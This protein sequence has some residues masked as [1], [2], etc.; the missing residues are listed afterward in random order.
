MLR[1]MVKTLAAAMIFA[2]AA[3]VVAQVAQG[4]LAPAAPVRTAEYRLL[5]GDEIA[6]KMPLNPELDTTGPIGPDGRFSIP[7]AGRVAISGLTLGE[8][9]RAITASLRDGRIVADPKPGIVVLKYTG[10]VYV[11]GE[12][13]KPGP[14]PVAQ[15]LDPLQAIIS[16][17]GLLNTA[18]SRK[19]AIIH[20]AAAPG[21]PRIETVDVR[22]IVRTG[23]TGTG[24]RPPLLLQPGD[25]IFVPKSTIAEVDQFVDQYIN[26]IVPNRLNFNVNLHNGTNTT[27][28]SITP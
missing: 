7:L 18:R 17:G 14:V 28:T 11:G 8:A 16:A 3:P 6:V 2:G 24:A 22:D 20:Q 4:N 15:G 1:A 5:P 10:V 19:V 9:E 12:V 27:T 13:R 25:V 26:G 21:A 23:E